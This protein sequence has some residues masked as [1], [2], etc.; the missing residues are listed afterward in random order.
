MK[1]SLVVLTILFCFCN[2]VFPVGSTAGE[3]Y[4]PAIVEAGPL[5]VI[6]EAEMVHGIALVKNSTGGGL[7]MNCRM[8]QRRIRV[9][10]F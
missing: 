10:Y 4:P 8:V 6:I 2:S 3:A 1:R 7:I 5:P 9:L